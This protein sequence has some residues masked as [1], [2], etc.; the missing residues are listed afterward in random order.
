M[1]VSTCSNISF[2]L[3]PIWLQTLVAINKESGQTKF[4]SFSSAQPSDVL[5]LFDSNLS[6]YPFLRQVVNLD[7]LL[8]TELDSEHVNMLLCH[9]FTQRPM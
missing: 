3:Q 9:S 6:R 5:V 8:C 4:S 2:L 1:L 7:L